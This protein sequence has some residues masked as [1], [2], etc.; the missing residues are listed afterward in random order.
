[1]PVEKPWTPGNF[2]YTKGAVLRALSV[3]IRRLGSDQ[4]ETLHFKHLHNLR[5][6]QKKKYRVIRGLSCEISEKL[7]M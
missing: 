2:V 7:K 3:R 5:Q 6:T 4:L 1:M